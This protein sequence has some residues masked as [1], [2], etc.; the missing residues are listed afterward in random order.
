[1]DNIQKIPISLLEKTMI[2]L[3]WIK[4]DEKEEGCTVFQPKA[5][6]KIKAYIPDSTERPDYI[7]HQ[8]RNVELILY[9]LKKESNP[10]NLSEIVE[11]IL[12]PNYKLISRIVNTKDQNVDSVPFE[13][14]DR[15]IKYN[16]SSFK[17][18]YVLTAAKQIPISKFHMNH[19]R[20]GSF[21]IPISIPAEYDES[22]LLPI[23]SLTNRVLK[24]YLQKLD[25]LTKLDV[26]D[27]KLF[28][29]K[30]IDNGISS[31]LVKDFMSED[32]LVK[33]TKQ[34]G[35]IINSVNV[36][37]ESSPIVDFQLSNAEK[38]FSNVELNKIVQVPNEYISYLEHVEIQREQEAI[39]EHDTSI[40]AV[41]DSLAYKDKGRT[42]AGAKF[43]IYKVAGEKLKKP[44]KAVATGLTRKRLKRFG[45]RRYTAEI[46]KI[47]GDITKAKGKIGDLRIEEILQVDTQGDLFDY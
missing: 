16:I 10:Q 26:K 2:F 36:Y 13:Y 44:F 47:M 6:E 15:V 41:V 35:Q 34:Y 18:E 20:K 17:T 5:N 32:G 21:I 1:M 12:F 30:V 25:V 42:E 27:E 29:T 43:T 14:A 19:T 7:F 45:E 39:D 31:R 38:V 3:G 9:Q 4:N 11:Q 24:G 33:Y 46:V 40:E 37:G 23:P 22:T 28:A 8:N